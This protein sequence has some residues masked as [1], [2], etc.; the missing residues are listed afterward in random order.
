MSVRSTNNQ[1]T[2]MKTATRLYLGGCIALSLVLGACNSGG[3][4]DTAAT[5]E[6]AAAA[7]EGT[8]ASEAAAPAE[9]AAPAQEIAAAP[10]APAD[11]IRGPGGLEEKCLARVNET[12][13]GG[14]IGTNRID[15]A[16]S[17]IAIYVNVDGAT[18]PWRC[19]GYR[20]GTIEEVMFTGDEGAL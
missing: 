4:A 14:V 7:E 13:G 20:N 11:P 2:T 17:G 18:A 12:V 16:E 6:E 8:D 15:E 9:E 1:E 3:E 10:A 5:E 19:F